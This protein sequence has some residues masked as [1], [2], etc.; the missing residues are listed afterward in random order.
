MVKLDELPEFNPHT[1]RYI[2]EIDVFNT[3]GRRIDAPYYAEI[4]KVLMK[5]SKVHWHDYYDTI[6]DVADT[7]AERT[8]YARV[9][10]PIIKAKSGK[11]FSLDIIAGWVLQTRNT[12]I[13]IREVRQRLNERGVYAVE[14][15]DLEER[16]IRRFYWPIMGKPYVH[17]STVNTD[18][19]T[20]FTYK[21]GTEAKV[22]C[23]SET[24]GYGHSK[25]TINKC[26]ITFPHGW[27]IWARKHECIIKEYDGQYGRLIVSFKPLHPDL[28]MPYDWQKN[29]ELGEVQLLRRGKGAVKTLDKPVCMARTGDVIMM[30]DE[31]NK[32]Y[33]GFPKKVV[34]AVMRKL[35]V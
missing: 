24:R 13:S 35:E 34:K 25:Y 10:Q 31:V 12:I 6:R 5:D 2:R 28:F 20:R 11:K 3:R 8:E 4:S 33:N 26:T 19:N 15:P 14:K 7:I 9:L 23:S 30:A 18:K 32:L 27:S 17:G 22:E 16:I 1:R 29:W 21:R